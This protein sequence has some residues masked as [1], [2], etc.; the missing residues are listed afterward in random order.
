[1]LINMNVM[2]P[3]NGITE[4]AVFVFKFCYCV[5]D[6]LYGISCI[7]RRKYGKYGAK[8]LSELNNFRRS[9]CPI[10]VKIG[11]IY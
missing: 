8:F 4:I 2:L 3:F 9:D 7:K 1:M 6:S 11:N 5:V 10:W